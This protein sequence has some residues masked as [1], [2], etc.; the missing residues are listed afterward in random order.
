MLSLLLQPDPEVR[1][2]Q[3]C[4]R[5]RRQRQQ[6]NLHKKQEQVQVQNQPRLQVGVYNT[7]IL[8]V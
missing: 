6:Q 8:Y 4:Q 3:D 7:T 2:V 5:P 1:R